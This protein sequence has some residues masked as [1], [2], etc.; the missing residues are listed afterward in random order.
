MLAHF[1]DNFENYHTAELD[2]PSAQS[3]TSHTD[4]TG[5]RL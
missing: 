5:K 1:A 3:Q 4:L 2:K